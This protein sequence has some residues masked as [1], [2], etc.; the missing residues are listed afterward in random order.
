MTSGLYKYI[1]FRPIERSTGKV[2]DQPCHRIMGTDDD[3]PNTDWVAQ[4]HWCVPLYYRP[5]ADEPRARHR[6]GRVHRVAR[7]RPPARRHGHEPVI[8]DMRPSPWHDS[9]EVE[10]VLGDVRRLD[11]GCAAARLRGVATWRRRPTSR[12]SA[13]IR[14]APRSST[15]AARSGARGGAARRDAR[16]VYASTI[17]V[18]SDVDARR[19]DEDTP[20]R[21]PAHLYTATKLAGELYC[22]S[23]A[24]L[25]G[26]EY[27]IL[28]FGIP[29]GPRARPAAVIPSIVV[30]GSRRRAAVDRRDGEQTRRFVYV[31]DLAEGVVRGAGSCAA[32]RTYNLAGDA[33]RHDPRSG[34]DRPG[35]RSAPVEIVHTGPRRR[36]A[37]VDDRQR[38]RRARTRLARFDAVRARGSG[39][40]RSGR[41]R[42]RTTMPPGSRARRALAPG[43]SGAR[44]L[45]GRSATAALEPSRL[46]FVVADRGRSS[47]LPALVST[48]G[49]GDAAGVRCRSDADGAAVGVPSPSG[50]SPCGGFKRRSRC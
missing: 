43:T 40:T 30:A 35:R 4:N 46:G 15:R 36:P 26:V 32:N 13:R 38:P 25:Y 1:V 10:T 3:L 34:G 31:E 45:A 49:V 47:L 23:Y 37:G 22:R 50:C 12:R 39:A 7:R 11:D 28:R 20:L 17:W 27:T 14:S 19:V 41:V 48:R 42:T 44:S 16:V 24:E 9:A 21:P 8:Y 5:E 33:R 6:R 2:Y 18:Y 29:Y